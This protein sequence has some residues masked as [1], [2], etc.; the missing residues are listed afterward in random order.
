MARL[1]NRQ[2]KHL[3]SF[4]RKLLSLPVERHCKLA[5]CK[6]YCSSAPKEDNYSPY[7]L[8]TTNVELCPYKNIY[9]KTA[10]FS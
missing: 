3:L 9:N 6:T 2:S 4:V 10:G 8:K 7:L 1:L 5:A